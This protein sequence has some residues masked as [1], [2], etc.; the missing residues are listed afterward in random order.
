VGNP[1]LARRVIEAI[2]IILKDPNLNQADRARFQRIGVMIAAEASNL[3]VILLGNALDTLADVADRIDELGE[4]EIQEMLKDI[5]GGIQ[6]DFQKSGGSDAATS[7]AN[8]VID[9]IEISD[10]V[11]RF[12]PGT[13][14]HEA[15]PS[16]VAKTILV[17]LLATMEES[18]VVDN[19]DDWDNFNLEELEIGLKLEDNKVVLDGPTS[20][21]ALVLAAY[22]NLIFEDVDGKFRDNFLTGLITDAV[23]NT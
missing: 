4:D 2:L 23:G 20:E 13:F 12:P 10:G 15:N 7:I 5:L 6:D 3:G 11:P 1:N 16:E 14:V 17:L 9:D 21:E 19:I 18:E 22:L 8:L